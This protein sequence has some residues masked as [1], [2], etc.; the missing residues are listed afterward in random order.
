MRHS[1]RSDILDAALRVVDAVGGADITYDS[2][3]REAGLTKAGLMYHFA[4]K[5]AMMI[6]LIEHVIARWQAELRDVLGVPLEESSLPDRVRA[7]V[8]F[9]GE[10][11]ATQGEFVVF[12]EAVRRPELSAPWLEYVRTWF[13][14]GT[15]AENTPLLLVWL[16]ANGL[17]IS[18][19]TGVLSVTAEQ[20]T[21]LLGQLTDLV[22]G[23]RS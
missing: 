23:A 4:T 2:V 22:A 10:G 15:G 3:A 9:A 7:F 12:S 19:A 17:W 18:E 1:S 8:R 16:A 21:A 11:G 5:D 20:R 6:A 14:F 13:G